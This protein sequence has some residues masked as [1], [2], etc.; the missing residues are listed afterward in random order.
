MVNVLRIEQRKQYVCIKESDHAGLIFVS[1][2]IHDL[3]GN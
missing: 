2:A 3:R 1:E